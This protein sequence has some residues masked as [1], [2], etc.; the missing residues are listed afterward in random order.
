ML[1]GVCGIYSL[2]M[3]IIG[4]Y[5]PDDTTRVLCSCL[6][7]SLWANRS[8]QVIRQELTTSLFLFFRSSITRYS[9]NDSRYRRNVEDPENHRAQFKCCLPSCL[10]NLLLRR[11]VVDFWFKFLVRVKYSKKPRLDRK[12]FTTSITYSS[13]H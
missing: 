8:Y 4:F 13:R 9:Y 5:K 12:F 2:T 1:T 7:Y 6:I 11:T 10:S 3:V